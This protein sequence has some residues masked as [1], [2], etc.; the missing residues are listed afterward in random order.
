MV[1]QSIKRAFD[2]IE[3]LSENPYGVTLTTLSELVGLH[4]ST[5]HRI[6][7]SLRELR[8]AEQSSDRTW[9]PGAG[10]V[11]LSSKL[12]LKDDLLPAALSPVDRLWKKSNETV[13]LAILHGAETYDV[14]AKESPCQVRCSARIGQRMPLHATALGKVLLAYQQ[15]NRLESLLKSLDLTK[16]TQDTI[17]D[18][19]YLKSH[20]KEI[21]EKG[22]AIN[23]SEYSESAV[24]MAA[25]VMNF[26][27]DV[28]AAL[29]IGIPTSRFDKADL[30]DIVGLVIKEAGQISK[31]L[32]YFT[33][34][35]AAE[36]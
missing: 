2:I 20:L 32:G 1:I 16:H 4:I 3:V 7:N 21:R 24:A 25:P 36:F 6:L 17:T 19:D 34:E 29:G 8:Y 33:P 35:R 22:Y 11:G 12:L 23:Y 13:H 10:L 27:G 26:R 9:K 18:L 28:V 31:N 15:G 14:I 5:T 30:Q